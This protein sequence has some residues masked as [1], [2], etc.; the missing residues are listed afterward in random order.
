M[1]NLDKYN[2]VLATIDKLFTTYPMDDQRVASDN[3]RKEIIDFKVKILFVGGFNAGKSTLINS[4]LERDLLKEEQVPE[5]AIATELVFDQIE[6]AILLRRDGSLINCPIENAG[7]Y[8]A[9]DFTKFVFKVNNNILKDFNDYLIVDMPGFDSGIEDHNIA[10][11]QYIEECVV[12]IFLV[13]CEKGTISDSALNF[14]SE[15][16]NYSDNIGFILNK[17]DKQLPDNLQ[18]IKGHIEASVSGTTG[19]NPVL[20]VTS[21]YDEDVATKIYDLIKSFKPQQIL[22]EKFDPQFRV[23]I[24]NICQSLSTIR[25]SMDFNPYE[26][27]QQISAREKSKQA[28]LIS[29]NNEKKA[30]HNKLQNTV[31]PNILTDI[32]VALSSGLDTLASSLQAGGPAFSQA[33]NNIIR[34]VLVSSIEKNIS[35]TFTEFVDNLI[36]NQ[37]QD[38]DASDIANNVSTIFNKLKDV[39][40]KAESY[41][42]LYKTIMTALSVTTTV[43]APWLELILIFLPEILTLFSG[44]MQSKQ[45]N[46]LKNRINEE[47]I[48]NILAKLEPAIIQSLREAEDKMLVEIKEYFSQL[49]DIEINA[50]ENLKN[51]K[52]DKLSDLQDSRS[53]I[54]SS[55][56]ELQQLA[57]TLTPK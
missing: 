52:A 14:L 54:D 43:V 21:K 6:S 17:S 1:F 37:D 30:L 56:S 47:I 31:K 26:I 4:L 10:L 16:M 49:I 40:S 42:G 33:V 2:I 13:D 57:I 51:L 19:I 44:S 38:I 45:L 50:L 36:I 15:I 18:N 3:L 11:M 27:D 35:L 23:L 25:G 20:I 48:P 24:E 7:D 34:P 46:T 39:S 29:L 22:E 53:E 12:Y 9:K 5:T 41:N 28:L 8:A 32:R 55:I